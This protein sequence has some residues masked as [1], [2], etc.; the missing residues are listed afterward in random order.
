MME[1]FRN[2]EY[3]S[4]L[5][6]PAVCCLLIM[7]SVFAENPTAAKQGHPCWLPDGQGRYFLPHG[8]VTV[9]EDPTGPVRYTADDYQRMLR[10][11]ANCQVIRLT[12]GKLGGWPGYALQ[13]DYLRQVDEMVRLGREAGLKTAFKMTV[14]GI[15]GFASQ[16]GWN[17]L[18]GSHDRQQSLI[19]TW[20]IIWTRYRNDPSVFGYDL[21]NEPFRGS[22][23]E[24]YE[25][26]TNERLIPLYRKI[27]DNL[28][29]IS[30]EKWA[31]YQPLLLDKEDRGP[32]KLPMAPMDLPLD[33]KKIIFAPHGYFPNAQ[34]H[35]KAI[36]RHLREAEISS[37]PLMMGELGRQ[38]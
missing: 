9:T 33:R 1:T 12:L 35:A 17:L 37:A 22:L 15:K 26:V 13:E 19:K 16:E 2:R 36:Q 25:Q 38:T 27:I 5:I 21:L 10:Y 7:N 6:I 8:Y 32:G 34:L 20:R 18:L 24:S 4:P 28:H 14:Y 3:P 31:L 23:A 29:L 11:G 30:P